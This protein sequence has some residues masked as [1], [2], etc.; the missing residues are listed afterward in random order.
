MV[1]WAGHCL[2]F[3]ASTLAGIALLR[4]VGNVTTST[5]SR[6]PGRLSYRV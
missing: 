1:T 4:Q 2:D 3:P 5:P 6:T